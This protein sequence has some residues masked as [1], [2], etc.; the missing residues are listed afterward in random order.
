MAEAR[1]TSTGPRSPQRPAAS[2]TEPS[3]PSPLLGTR[4]EVRTPGVPFHVTAYAVEMLVLLHGETTCTSPGT[5]VPARPRWC[6]CHRRTCAV[7]IRCIK[8]AES[9]LCSGHK[10]LPMVRRSF[11]RSIRGTPSRPVRSCCSWHAS[12]LSCRHPDVKNRTYPF[13]SPAHLTAALID[14]LTETT[15]VFNMKNCRTLRGKI[16]QAGE[17]Q[18]GMSFDALRHAPPWFARCRYRPC[19]PSAVPSPIGTT[20]PNG[21]PNGARCR[22]PASSSRTGTKAEAAAGRSTW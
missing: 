6:R 21:T 1:A 5:N 16:D 9:L 22:S 7:V 12:E 11:P 17:K 10:T 3:S 15:H 2:T 14:R 19:W 13:L 8:V 20:G 4:H 18:R